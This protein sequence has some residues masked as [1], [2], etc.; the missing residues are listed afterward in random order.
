MLTDGQMTLDDERMVCFQGL[1]IR[2]VIYKQRCT[3]SILI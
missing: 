2:D 3:V 1:F